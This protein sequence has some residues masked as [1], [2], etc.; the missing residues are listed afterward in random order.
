MKVRQKPMV[1]ETISAMDRKLVITKF[2]DPRARKKSE[3]RYSLRELAEKLPHRI[4]SEKAKLPLLKLATFGHRKTAKG[5]FR[6][7]ANILMIEGVEGDYDGEAMSVAEAAQ[8]LR[9]AKLA[10]LFYTSPS[11]TAGKPRWRVLCPTSRQ[12]PASER[13]ILISRLMGVL[14]GQLAS[15]SFTLSQTYYYGTVERKKDTQIT[16]VEGRPI[17]FAD[18]L[19]ASALD[20]NGE[21]YGLKIEDDDDPID[22]ENEP[23]VPRIERALDE[24]PVTAIEPYHRWLEIGQALHHEFKGNLDGLDLWDRASQFCTTYDRQELE[25]KWASFGFYSGRPI[26]IGTLFRLAKNHESKQQKF[27]ELRFLSTVD[28]S[29]ARSRGYVVKGMIAPGNIA[30]IFG[31]PGAG[32]S[33]I[34][35][36]IGYQVA[37]GETAFG[38]RTRAGNV[39][40][41][42]AEDPHGMKGRIKALTIRQGHVSHF[43]LV[44]GLSD[45]FVHDSKDMEAL[46]KAVQEKRPVLIIIDTLAMA[47]PGLEENDAA[48]MG[49][50]VAVARQL[51]KNDAAVLLVHHDTKAE[52]STPRGHSLFNGALDMALQVKRNDDGVV[53]SKLTKNRNGSADHNIAFRIGTEE[54]GKDDDGDVITAAVV[55]ELTG[56]EAARTR[57][58]PVSQREALTILMELESEGMVSN[59]R[60]AEVSTNG[61]RVSQSEDR[62]SRQ[63]AFRRARSGLVTSGEVKI[64]SSG[65]AHTAPFDDDQ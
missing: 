10:A 49:R 27:G 43:H 64:D 51:A 16:L 1:D 41:V 33:L 30:C 26:T 48:S 37:L 8:K 4:A 59:E 32:K 56:S 29:V 63:T 9:D 21:P 42:A 12:L 22:L 54:I 11:H 40:Y 2:P 6:N 61:F 58:K 13:E 3:L 57:K 28:C 36:H 45:L 15:E 23:D 20:K 5:S 14:D 50:V 17:D 18:E 47:F 25:E 62:K 7:N 65:N 34:G 60:W 46:E 55:E 53:R 35:P 19:D 44:E 39:F 52:G 38:M 24:L 31:A